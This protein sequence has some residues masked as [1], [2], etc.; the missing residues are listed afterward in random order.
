M[1][2]HSHPKWSREI[3]SLVLSFCILAGS[4]STAGAQETGVRA[5]RTPGVSRDAE[6]AGLFRRGRGSDFEQLL[7]KTIGA[8]DARDVESWLDENNAAFFRRLDAAFR[9]GAE[10]VFEQN[11]RKNT[12][13]GPAI[14]PQPAAPKA[15]APAQRKPSGGRRSAAFGAAGGAFFQKASFNPVG[16]DSFD[17]AGAP[18][19]EMEVTETETDD[20]FQMNG[21]TEKTRT[22]GDVTIT[23]GAKGDA[24]GIGVEGGNIGTEYKG[25]EYV[26]AVHKEARQSLR[27]ETIVGWRILTA[28]CPDADGVSAGT[29]TMTTAVKKTITNPQTIAI[30]TRDITTRMT[31]KGYVNDAAELTHFDLEGAATET[32]SGYERAQRLGLVENVEYADGEKQINYSLTNNKVGLEV[33]DFYG[34]IKTVGEDQIG[35]VEVTRPRGVSDAEVVRIDKVAAPGVG[36]LH[37]Q[38]ATYLKAARYSWRNDG[39]VEVMLSAPKTSLQ[40]GEQV[41]VSAETVHQF[42]KIKVNAELTARV[43]TVSASPK[44]QAG[45][46]QG[47]FILTAPSQG[48]RAYIAVESVSRRGI[49]WEPLEFVEEKVTKNPVLPK[50]TPPPVE[51]FPECWSG[52]ITIVRRSTET[53]RQDGEKKGVR[54]TTASAAT[55]RTYKYDATVNITNARAVTSGGVSALNKQVASA[56]IPFTAEANATSELVRESESTSYYY[57]NCGETETRRTLYKK[58]RQEEAGAGQVVAEGAVSVDFI[59][60]R[61]HF[62]VIVP[63]LP[64]KFLETVIRRP[65]G[66]CRPEDNRPQD[67]SSEGSIEIGRMPFEVTDGVLDPK[68][69]FVI[70]GSRPFTTGGGE[71]VEI[72]WSLRSC[73]QP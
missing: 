26:E 17:A 8:T 66:Y 59:N 60:N 19:E 23:Q 52:T 11:R 24:R 4:F 13:A 20:G 28:S 27:T 10:R 73:R 32:I 46:P 18:Q 6:Y 37:S 56:V 7:A 29:A 51:R 15:S 25:V 5:N 61:Y 39:C 62:N 42:D 14:V 3:F 49:A 53:W 12:P 33:R 31:I 72:R 45:A 9:S 41:E 58:D 40:P 47:K 1:R 30:L 68:R 43:A 35:E 69:P 50:K 44:K 54:T 70:E 64:G 48:D 65:S 67:S 71:E 34:S 63:P 55:L 16:G 2:R 22:V 57:D 21:A 38:A 36:W